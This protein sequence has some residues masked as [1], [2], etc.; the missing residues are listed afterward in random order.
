MADF[1]DCERCLNLRR[2]HA[3]ATADQER[4]DSRLRVAE[5]ATPEKIPF[6][7]AR[8]QSASALREVVESQIRKHEIEA[9]SQCLIGY[10]GVSSQ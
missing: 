2:Q 1:M 8:M 7:K 4:V 3:E 6:L 9:H 10:V 5:F